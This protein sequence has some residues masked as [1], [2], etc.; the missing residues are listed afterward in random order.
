MPRPIHASARFSVFTALT[1]TL[2]VVAAEIAATWL[3]EQF[4]A[5][6]TIHGLFTGSIDD[7]AVDSTL[8]IAAKLLATAAVA[9]WALGRTGEGWRDTGRLGFSPAILSLAF[10]PLIAGIIIALSEIDNLLRA[11]L[12]ADLLSR[13]DFAPDLG[14]L[15]AAS[16][17]GP[18]LAVVIAPL[19]E[20]FVFRGLIL[21]GLL[22]RWPAG[23]AILASAA[24]FALTHF[25]PAQ[26][27][28]ALLLGALLGWIYFRTRSLGL[29]M[30]GHALNNAT[31]YL[32]S[33]PFEI[34]GFNHVPDLD[35]P[36]FHPWWFDAL[37][38]GLFAVGLWWMHR[39][40][41]AAATWR[42]A[43]PVFS[44]AAVEPSL[45]EPPFLPAPGAA[46][47]TAPRA[48]GQPGGGPP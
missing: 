47:E 23:W 7:A 2:L 30:F 40:A 37:A 5:L 39:R 44:P 6:G 4:Y 32:D 18:V 1:I 41:P 20:E 29:C 17:Q 3:V 45:P 19:T 24:L 27:P 25:N 13:L 36:V 16:W 42:I 8:L 15:V 38:V 21:R 31:T 22:G 33:F 9:F 48:D 35:G 26:A 11:L 28:V 14:D 46:P 43:P 34:A 12:P 10:V